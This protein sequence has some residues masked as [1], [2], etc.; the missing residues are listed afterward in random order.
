LRKSAIAALTLTVLVT[1]G[2]LR[3]A[4][5]R[6]SRDE[7]L[8][9]ADARALNL[10]RILSAYLVESFAASDA[11]L[12]QIVTHG[13]RLGGIEGS[14]AD[15]Q[16]LLSA[17]KVGLTGV[18]AITVV[19]GEGI[20]RHSTRPE[21]IG[22]SR[23]DQP[24][25]EQALN[26]RPGELFVG[27]PFPT[28]RPGEFIIP[29][30][31]P[32]TRADGTVE[33]LVAASFVPEA[34]RQFFQTVNVGK[35]GMIWVFHPS[36]ELLFREPSAA[37]PIGQR[38]TQNPIFVAAASQGTGSIMAPLSS[39]GPMLLSAF[40]T[41]KTP[42]LIVAAS[43][44]R[45]EVLAEWRREARNST[46]VLAIIALLLIVTLFVLFRQMDAKAGAE[47]ALHRAQE[48]EAERLRD[49][50]EREQAARREAERANALKEQF[51]MTISHELRTPLTAIAGWARMLV[52]GTVRDEQRTTALRSIE[53]NARAQTRL[54]DDLLDMS[55]A[56]N[57]KVRLDLRMVDLSDVVQQAVEAMA[58]A[59]QAKGIRIE[60][61]VDP[62]VG[63]IT[64]D[65]DRLQQ[66]VWNLLSNAVKFTPPAGRVSVNVAA[67]RDQ[68][69][70]IVSDTGVGMSPDFLPHAFERFRQQDAGSNRRFGG[71][72]LGLAIVRHLVELHG[73]SI[74]A[75][76]DGEG[77]GSTFIVRLPARA[78]AGEATE[79]GPQP[80]GA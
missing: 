16:Q 60:T 2:A 44:D 50:L 41:S 37:N 32:L 39:G 25:F 74:A 75:S 9:M 18:G 47:R 12:R 46:L 52:E 38:A 10:S 33:G 73:G 62:T 59:A 68:V 34:A 1:M 69:A 78:A 28:I 42:P 71:L 72:G 22:Q 17:T 27:T 80:V 49:A 63:P 19:D 64:A 56:I 23:R 67:E 79:A 15:W 6:W 55:R 11:A 31:R 76:S 3:A 40:Y 4:D 43:L 61:S 14:A 29:I 51:L 53:R 7:T 48:A 57:G 45:D 30:T 20:I 5:L 66:V 8:R 26:G 70:I 65:P 13:S 36:G 35:R 58:P 24:V 21:I 77:C 54:I